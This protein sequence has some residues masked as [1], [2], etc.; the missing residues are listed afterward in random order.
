MPEGPEVFRIA[1]HL[2]TVVPPWPGCSRLESITFSTTGSHQPIT[3]EV[4][5]QSSSSSSTRE[6]VNLDVTGITT[7]GKKLIIMLNGDMAVLLSFVLEGGLAFDD[8]SSSDFIAR[9]VF[10]ILP[11]SAS[12]EEEASRSS[13]AAQQQ[14]KKV[15][16][17]LVDHMRWA[18]AVLDRASVIVDSL[19][20]AGFDP[21]YTTAGMREWLSLCHSHKNQLV[22]NFLTNQSYIAGIGNKYR[23]EIMH[24]A[25]VEP[26]DHIRD[27]DDYDLEVLLIMISA[28]LN[29]ASRG[30][31]SS[32]V[33]NRKTVPETGESVFKVEVGRG[34]YIW[35]TTTSKKLFGNSSHHTSSKKARSL[36]KPDDTVGKASVQ[37]SVRMR[38]TAHL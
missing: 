7:K 37:K 8:A 21:L 30:E 19:L 22:A 5:V 28:I 16:V 10:V 38:R 35:T 24:A 36:Q 23:S 14:H 33:H 29:S 27:L 4:V 25:G 9:M 26:Y 17:D 3:D 32:L 15:V 20:P 6:V 13:A 12:T 1:Q 18:T 11:S 31:Y 34:V 2:R